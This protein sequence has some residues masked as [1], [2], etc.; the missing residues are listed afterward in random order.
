ML[1]YEYDIGGM[2]SASV[3]DC[4]ITYCSTSGLGSAKGGVMGVMGGNVSIHSCT[5]LHCTAT[6]TSDGDA[7]GAVIHHIAFNTSSTS[8]SISDCAISHCSVVAA[9]HARAGAVYKEAGDLTMTAVTI[10]HCS[11][12]ATGIQPSYAG[13]MYCE[14]LTIV[15]NG[16]SMSHCFAKSSAKKCLGGVMYIRDALSRAAGDFTSTMRDCEIRCVSSN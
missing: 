13:A 11:A 5:I 9:K 4:E 15:L 16:C 2:G 3:A 12:T 1:F 6:S 8:L 10:S 7:L 14:D